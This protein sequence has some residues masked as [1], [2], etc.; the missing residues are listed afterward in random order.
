MLLVSHVGKKSLKMEGILLPV[1]GGHI[2]AIGSLS[3]SVL[4]SILSLTI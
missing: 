1:A 4:T 2:T 3:L